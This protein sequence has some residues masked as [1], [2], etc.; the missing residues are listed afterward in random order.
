[1]KSPRDPMREFVAAQEFVTAPIILHGQGG[2][3]DG[4]T[5]AR[6]T[7]SVQR[8]MDA[9]SDVPDWPRGALP[10]ARRAYLHAGGNP[11]LACELDAVIY[12]TLAPHCVRCSA[13]VTASLEQPLG[14]EWTR[15]RWSVHDAL[16]SAAR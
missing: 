7:R 1:M 15:I 14:S 16:P 6:C 3:D 9:P 2:W 5:L 12:L 13:G 4:A 11:A 8:I 10:E